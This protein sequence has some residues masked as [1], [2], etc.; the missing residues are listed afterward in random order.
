MEERAQRV[1]GRLELRSATG[2]GSLVRLLL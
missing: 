1:G 2:Q